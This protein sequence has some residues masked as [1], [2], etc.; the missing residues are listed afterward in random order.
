MAEQQAAKKAAM[1]AQISQANRMAYG[2]PAKAA[3]IT[4][5]MPVVNAPKSTAPPPKAQQVNAPQ[6]FSFHLKDVTK[7]LS[8]DG[9]VLF[10]DLNL[11][12]YEG[13]KIGILGIN[14]SGKS[15][16]IK[17]IAGVDKDF[18]GEVSMVGDLSVGY[19]PQEPN[20]NPELNVHDNILMG[21]KEKKAILDEYEEL[22]AQLERVEKNEEV[23]ENLAALQ[24]R[25]ASLEKM[26][27]TQRLRDLN[28]KISRAID[29]LNC[30]N[31]SSS[32]VN[33]SGGEKRRV[34]LARLLISAPDILLLDEPTNHLDADSVAWLERYLDEYKG[35]VLAITHD[36]YFLDRVASWIL[37]MDRGKCHPFK[38][39]Y[40]QWLLHKE[41]RITLENKE[42]KSQKKA[43]EKELEWIRS[44]PKARQTKNKNRIN[45]F[46]KMQ[47]AS[48]NAKTYTN[49]GSIIIKPGP[50][51]GDLV[52]KGDKIS[53][54]HDG[55]VLFKDF[56]FDIPKGAIIGIIGPNGAG[57]TTLF[58][59]IVGLENVD[60]GSVK[61]GGSVRMAH[62]AQVR[63]EQL[64][65]DN[66]VYEEVSEGLEF[67]EVAGEKIN[68]RAYL[69]S[70][71][72]RATS[73]SKYVSSLSGGERN[74]LQLAKMLKRGC[75]LILLDEPT[76][77]LDVDVLRSLE[78]ALGDFPGSAIIISHD[79]WFLDRM[80][81]HIMGFEGDGS[82][83]FYPGNYTEY[84]AD[85]KKRLGDSFG[86]KRFKKIEAV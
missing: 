19:L 43:L 84:E 34:A 69:A 53:K 14:G 80:C 86:Q 49:S 40:T 7:I 24:K 68:M 67:F 18:D 3:G 42:N 58:N 6:K 75:N 56:S 8:A 9:R 4:E 73:Q 82:V 81:T 13:A 54:S 31:G 59:C 15:S 77:D 72:F 79:R 30:P 74:R 52:I 45:A 35:T 27:E 20:L 50:R 33:L 61:I 21:V 46:E 63:T 47:E 1:M 39:N 85:R 12:A 44:T 51:L 55:K 62:V 29:A 32:V 22:T 48:E 23:G 37:E 70:F 57:K 5:K 28:R 66:T 36:R 78:E 64:N 25:H 60:S 83:Y 17:I 16:L 2:A 76:N 26:V 38:G 41:R 10:Q 11:S 71:N 65:G